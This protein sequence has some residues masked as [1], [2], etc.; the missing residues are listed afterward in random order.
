MRHD[1]P[2]DNCVLRSS[3]V[4]MASTPHR[5]WCTASITFRRELAGADRPVTSLGSLLPQTPEEP[6]AGASDALDAYPTS[7]APGLE[8][9]KGRCRGG[10]LTAVAST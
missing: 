10:G 8:V 5:P 1:M 3:M 6:F 2:E 4:V 7:P 9:Q